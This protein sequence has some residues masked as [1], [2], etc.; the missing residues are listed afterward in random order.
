VL[1]LGGEF[2]MFGYEENF[3][4]PELVAD[5]I[6][7]ALLPAPWPCGRES[8]PLLGPAWGLFCNPAWAKGGGGLEVVLLIEALLRVLP[9]VPCRCSAGGGVGLA[10][11]LGEFMTLSR[12][13]E[14]LE[15]AVLADVVVL[16]VLPVGFW[17]WG[18]AGGRDE[19]DEASGGEPDGPRFFSFPLPFGGDGVFFGGIVMVWSFDCQDLLMV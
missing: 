12:N 6:I 18:A 7:S 8:S 11:A 15:V 1:V 19:R 13:V 2:M 4:D 10:L 3:L 17:R 5:V 16:C 14:V 9:P